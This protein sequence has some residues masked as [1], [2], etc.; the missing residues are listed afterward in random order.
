MLESKRIGS[1]SGTGCRGG[2]HHIRNYLL[3]FLASR[4]ERHLNPAGATASFQGV[5]CL[6]RLRTVPSTSWTARR[7]AVFTPF[8][9]TE[10]PARACRCTATW[11]RMKEAGLWVSPLSQGNSGFSLQICHM[12]TF[13]RSG[14]PAAPERP[15]WF[16]QEV[17][18][19]P[20][21]VWQSGGRIL[22]R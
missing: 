22:A 9:L 3:V 17:E 11:P 14:V 2:L 16:F 21:W 5:A 13:G 1:L 8:T 4:H 18:R 7:W 15:D 12:V 6:P 19:L 20:C 10:T